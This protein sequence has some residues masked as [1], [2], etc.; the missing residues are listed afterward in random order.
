MSTN[1]LPPVIAHAPCAA[2][3]VTREGEAWKVVANAAAN[4]LVADAGEADWLELLAA[5]LPRL[6]QQ[7][8]ETHLRL[9]SG[10]VVLCRATPFDASSWLIWLM[11]DTAEL[12]RRLEIAAD[13]AGVGLWKVH[14]RGGIVDWD[15][16]TAKMQGLPPERKM[17]VAQWTDE[18]VHP[19]D[20]ELVRQ[21]GRD[22]S[23]TGPIDTEI[24]F[25]VLRPDGALRWLHMRGRRDSSGGEPVYFGVVRDVTE[26]HRSEAALADAHQR[27]A[28]AVRGA[29]MGTWEH[30]LAT[31]TVFW[32]EQMFRLRGLEPD[33]LLAP[34]GRGRE[35]V[36]PDDRE[37]VLAAWQESVRSGEP[38]SYEFRVRWPDGSYRWLA[39]RL[40]PVTN[41]LGEVVRQIGVNWDITEAKTTELARQERA[42]ALRESQAKSQ[43]LAR[44]SH[45]LRTP[46]NAVLGFTQLLQLE[47]DGAVLHPGQRRKLEH[48]R[49]AAQHLLSLITDVLDLSSLESGGMRLNLQ[50]VDVADVV[51]EALPLVE[52]QARQRGVALDLQA[53]PGRVLADP[54]RLRQV[55]INLLSNAIKYNRFEGRVSVVA[56][57]DGS[58]VE[59]RILDTGAGMSSEQLAHLFEPFNRLGHEGS[60]IEG[61]G[62]G[63]AIVK[64]LVER[65]GGTIAVTSQPDQGSEVLLR[66][67]AAPA[68]VTAPAPLRS[69]QETTFA[70]RVALGRVVPEA[71]ILYIEDNPINV[72]LVQEVVA[73]RAAL[74]LVCEDAGVPGVERARELLPDLVL[75]DMRLPDIDGFEVLRRLR[76]DPLTA[77]IPCIALSA[78][79]L[80][81]HVASA[82]DAGFAAY[83]TKPLDI[84][85][86]LASLDSL[87]VTAP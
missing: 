7:P 41:E 15:A 73:T 64:A 46:L 49:S 68:G 1:P 75:I 82:L 29:G 48:V 5:R 10:A 37:P 69:V 47:I 13:A 34:V 50:S 2:L 23:R 35:L 70:E 84:N 55:L 78:D 3:H 58:E 56:R 30:D 54:T 67:P 4:R 8:H 14:Q 36:H 59:L 32:D 74:R 53:L 83:W 79:A 80:P 20:R 45:E 21:H 77:A 28:L 27:A 71:L 76:A 18:L 17:T 72:M 43:F 12:T 65:M 60:D 39:S 40:A 86:F 6:T 33:G 61:T 24:E 62:I 52:E 44:M 19:D 51:A 66:L 22:T 16:N 85:Q 25:R 57:L 38:V 63:L 9:T 87:F 81:G 42:L 31:L 11:P 26:R